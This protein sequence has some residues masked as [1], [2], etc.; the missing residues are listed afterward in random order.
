MLYLRKEEV[1]I[2]IITAKKIVAICLALAM[3]FTFKVETVYSSQELLK[4]TVNVSFV[5][6][7]LENAVKTMKIVLEIFSQIMYTSN[8]SVE[9]VVEEV[10]QKP[11]I[12]FIK[13]L[14]EIARELKKSIRENGFTYEY[15]VYY[16][17][18][19]YPPSNSTSNKTMNCSSFVSWTLYEYAKQRGNTVI[20]NEFKE[21]KTTYNILNYLISDSDNFIYVGKL[22][23]LNSEDLQVGDIIIK[24]GHAEILAE[25]DA[26]MSNKY[27]CYNAGSDK[28]MESGSSTE[29]KTGGACN[30]DTEDY[31]VYRVNF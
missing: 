14:A 5:Q 1:I 24:N 31:F 20:E 10:T 13:T 18:E 6:D 3:T 25:Y 27:R 7:V 9:P 28:A 22:H 17:F 26:S 12:I 29:E 11:P 23:E 2:S 4:E 21:S 15:F 30:S 19:L 8:N 16:D